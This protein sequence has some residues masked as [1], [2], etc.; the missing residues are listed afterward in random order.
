[1]AIQVATYIHTYIDRLNYNKNLFC[2]ANHVAL[3][4]VWAEIGTVAV[5]AQLA[6]PYVYMYIYVQR[7]YLSIYL[8]N[9]HLYPSIYLPIYASIALSI[10]PYIYIVRERCIDTYMDGHIG[11]QVGRYIPAQIDWI[12]IS[13]CF[14]LQTMS[15]SSKCGRRSGRLRYLRSSRV[16]MYICTYISIEIIFIYLSILYLYLSI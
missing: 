13:T 4:E 14:A 16:H 1:M 12:I 7:L 15:R 9:I 10:Y 6:R 2:V 11:R 3:I 5:L 8:Y